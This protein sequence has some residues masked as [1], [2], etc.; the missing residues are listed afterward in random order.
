[1]GY[2]KNTAADVFVF[3]LDTA[4]GLPK[5][6]DAANITARVTIDG[7]T[8]AASND[9][10][11]VEVDA[12]N[13]PGW[14]EF[15]ATAGEMNGDII[16]WTVSSSTSNIEFDEIVIHTTSGGDVT[17]INGSAAAA[18]RLALSAAQMIPGTVD[19]TAHTPTTTEFEADDITEATA[20]HYNGRVVLWTTGALAGQATLITDYVLTGGR[21]HFTVNTMTEAPANNDTFIII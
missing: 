11:P 7:G 18:A 10:N 1:M 4:T 21:G 6:G 3:A 13:H 16:I 14:Y 2:T 12:T 20:D 9:T 5:T 15:N 8:S 17:S 19:N